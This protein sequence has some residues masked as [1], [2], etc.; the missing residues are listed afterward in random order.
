VIAMSLSSVTLHAF[1]FGEHLEGVPQR[2]LGYRLLAPAEAEPWAAEVE[3]LARRLQAAPYP[4]HWPPTDLFCSVLMAD[5]R[6]LI[7][8]ARYG[9]A[10]HTPS[11]RRSGLELIGV[12]APSEVDVATALSIY[13]WLGRQRSETD[14]LRTLGGRHPLPE[15]ISDGPAL[16]PGG[17][18]VPVLPI[19]LWEHGALL[20]AATTPA[21][22]DHHLG[23]LEQGAGGAW[24][25]LPLVGS[26]FPLL[27]YAQRGPLV[28]WTPHL[29]GVAVKLDRRPADPTARPTT[30]RR[31]LQA[32]LGLAVLS[33]L[34]A[35]LWAT[36]SLHA[37]LSSSPP[38]GPAAEPAVKPSPVASGSEDGREPFALALHGLIQGQPAASEW[39]PSELR[40]TY[41]QLVSKDKRLRVSSPEGQ[42]LVGAVSLISRRSARQIESSVREA[43]AHKGYDAELIDLASRR[44]HDHLLGFENHR[45]D[46]KR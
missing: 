46:T 36:Y 34:G 4:D 39:S 29:A 10:D 24:Q 26:D 31:A 17:D 19:R 43:L 44:V 15:I 45:K 2:S 13:R 32:V 35:N 37:R 12:I 28:A 41:R 33:L 20:F 27:T 14:D 38:T 5:G 21:D 42:A 11:R 23:L 1:A 22:P 8:L 3:F 40:D 25:W 9:L 6:R 30:R 16:P 18:P 7:A